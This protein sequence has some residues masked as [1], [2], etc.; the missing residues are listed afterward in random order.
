MVDLPGRHQRPPIS[1]VTTYVWSKLTYDQTRLQ[2]SRS[3]PSCIT[4]SSS[5]ETFE[6]YGSPNIDIDKENIIFGGWYG[7]QVTTDI[8]VDDKLCVQGTVEDVKAA[9]S[10]LS[11]GGLRYLPESDEEGTLISYNNNTDRVDMKATQPFVCQV[12]K[13]KAALKHK[14]SKFPK[15]LIPASVYRQKNLQ[16]APKP[17][18]S[19]Q[20]RNLK[21]SHTGVMSTANDILSTALP[22]TSAFIDT[23]I[24]KSV[25][26]GVCEV[27]KVSNVSITAAKENRVDLV[28]RVESLYGITS[29]IEPMDPGLVVKHAI[30][31]L[32]EL[33]V[34]IIKDE[35]EASMSRSRQLLRL[36]R[37]EAKNTRNDR[38]LGT[39]AT[40]L[41]LTLLVENSREVKEIKRILSK[42]KSLPSQ[43][44]KRLR[45]KRKYNGIIH[46]KRQGLSRRHRSL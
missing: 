26:G 12:I 15:A 10:R 11:I 41:S 14:M 32:E 43:V 5:G 9:M 19:G 17:A 37:N 25:V 23:N 3:I 36:N 45:L 27:I 30:A 6:D 42:D 34:D 4:I 44:G 22:V 29:E 13:W 2:I 33:C 18:S 8:H 1:S 21:I 40:H 16:A 46:S 39:A 28:D 24:A 35:N 38:R 20:S 7:C 31:Q